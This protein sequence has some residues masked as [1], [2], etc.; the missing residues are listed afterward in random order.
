MSLVLSHQS[1]QLPS[2]IVTKAG[3]SKKCAENEFP[4]RSVANQT[5]AALS[6][7]D[8]QRKG[9]EAHW[10][11]QRIGESFTPIPT[12]ESTRAV[13]A[14]AAAAAETTE[15]RQSTKDY[16]SSIGGEIG[17]LFRFPLA[18]PFQTTT[19]T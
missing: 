7:I 18:F 8:F 10:G 3:E 14:K 6:S 13:E 1:Q 4:F 19:T 2:Q 15:A 12:L 17:F 11:S 5:F 16:E 9:K